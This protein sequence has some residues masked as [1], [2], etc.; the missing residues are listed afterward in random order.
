LEETEDMEES[1][2]TTVQELQHFPFASYSEFKRALDQNEVY[3]KI[4]RYDV[5]RAWAKGGK[6]CP[7]WL[8]S[9]TKLLLA[10][11]WMAA[12]I[13]GIYVFIT[14][15][16]RLLA[17]AIPVLV[18]AYLTGRPP[19][20][21]LLGAITLSL[22]N[23]VFVPASLL[24]VIFFALSKQWGLALVSFA[25]GLTWFGVAR[26][27]DKADKECALVVAEHEDMLAQFFD[28]NCVS[29]FFRNGDVYGANVKVINGEW[30]KYQDE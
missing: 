18:F 6:Y 9:E 21:T 5:V 10:F 20:Y 22:F 3:L 16:V 29:V 14:R 2:V 15:D 26:A 30:I 19:I 11:P 28:C 8:R 23:N 4:G 24:A 7:P 25:A 1:K 13:M 27:Y 17:W 12:A